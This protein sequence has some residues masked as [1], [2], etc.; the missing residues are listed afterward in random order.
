[1]MGLEKI[2]EYKKKLG[3]TT[4]ELSKRSGV[5]VGTL[6]K[7]LSGQTKD[8]KLETLKSIARVLNCT[9]DD[10]D[11]VEKKEPSYDELK[12]LIARNGKEMSTKDKMEL[13]KM[14]SEL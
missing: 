11:D 6:N 4:E 8:P 13:I 1:M 3:I 7:I 10:F 5:P 14:L 12:T 2:S 9:L